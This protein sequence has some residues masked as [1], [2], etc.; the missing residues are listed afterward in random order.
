MALW[1]RHP[2][3]PLD[4]YR[5]NCS[6]LVF[7]LALTARMPIEPSKIRAKGPY[8]FLAQSAGPAE[9]GSNGVAHLGGRWSLDNCRDSS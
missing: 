7:H 4:R 6:V 2:Y 8:L 1:P 9:P 5:P 3:P